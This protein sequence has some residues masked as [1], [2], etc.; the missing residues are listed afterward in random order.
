MRWMF[1]DLVITIIIEHHR[2]LTAENSEKWLSLSLINN[3]LIVEVK[4][5]LSSLIGSLRDGDVK[6]SGRPHQLQNRSKT[7]LFFG[8]QSFVRKITYTSV[9]NIV[10]QG[11]LN[12]KTWR[13]LCCKITDTFDNE[14]S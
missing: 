6:C 9:I 11:I 1:H 4:E 14:W 13:F 5:I 2:D 7:F 12:N 8:Q 10:K 3:C